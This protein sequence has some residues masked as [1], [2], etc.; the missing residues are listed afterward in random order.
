MDKLRSQPVEK[1]EQTVPA[2]WLAGT[3]SVKTTG[4]CI[5]PLEILL[6]EDDAGDTV[7]INEIISELSIPVNLHLARDGEQALLMLSDHLFE[8]DLV[9]L[10]LN[11]PRVSG[12]DVLERR[13]FRTV[14][15]VVFTGSAS[16]ADIQRSLN[17][18][19]QEYI[20]KPHDLDAYREIVRGIV[21]KRT[22]R[23][24]QASEGLP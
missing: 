19:A 21:E 5:S 4:Q 2:P 20:R 8:P 3:E 12:Y 7:L 6:V 11:L 22:G 16:E 15:V 13:P 18:G 10:D 9:I 23:A 1:S 17:L 24:R 14:P